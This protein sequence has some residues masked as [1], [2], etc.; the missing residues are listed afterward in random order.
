MLFEPQN[1]KHTGDAISELTV[2]NYDRI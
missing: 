2:K 1:T